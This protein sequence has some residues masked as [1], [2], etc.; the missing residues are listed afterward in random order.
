MMNSMASTAAQN[1]KNTG[2]QQCKDMAFAILDDYTAQL[3][4]MV[5]QSTQGLSTADIR[6]FLE[7]Y[8]VEAIKGQEPMIRT[9]YQNCL[10]RCEQEVFDPATRREPFKRVITSRIVA[11]FPPL[12][13]LDE[14]GT[15]LSRRLLP[16]FFLAMEKMVGENAFN[17]GHQVCKDLVEVLKHT[18]QG[19]LWEDLLESEQAQAAVDDLL[20]S[21]LPH[22]DNPMKRMTWML[23]L[24]NND[25]ADAQE[26]HFEGPA[27]RDWLLDERGMIRLLRS[28]FEHLKQHLSDK[29]QAKQLASKYGV[30]NTRALL[31]LVKTLDKSDI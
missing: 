28:L 1:D 7:S 12:N 5:E 10:N 15:Y 29:D 25:L 14:R 24:I 4:T 2:S 31:A 3:I 18:N 16:G 9:H 17:Q 23:N 21:L 11:L 13:G 30:E 22:F 6:N 8:K 27:N 19:F 26:Y 20:M